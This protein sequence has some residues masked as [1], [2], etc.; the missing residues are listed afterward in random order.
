MTKCAGCGIVLQYDDPLKEGY[1]KDK[2]NPLCERCFRIKNYNEYKVTTRNNNDYLNILSNIKNNDITVVVLSLLEFGD[3]SL[4]N[5]TFGNN[6]ILCLTKRDLLP[7]SLIDEKIKKYFL[8]RVEC[9]D[10]V[11]VSSI[12]NY[13]IDEL[14]NVLKENNTKNGSFYFVGYTNAGK[15]TLINKLLKNYTHLEESL[16]SSA[17]PS[18]TLDTVSLMIDDLNIIDTPGIINDGSILNY[19]DY[20]KLKKYLPNKEMRPKIFQV[21][22]SGALVLDDLLVLRYDTLD[23]GSIIAF[24][25]NSANILH[26]KNKDKHV[27]NS[28]ITK[29]AVKNKELVIE[30]L[31]FFK[32]VGN[33][34]LEIEINK[35]TLV[36]TRD[37]LID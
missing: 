31:C 34:T 37:S 10:I 8:D 6:I 4:I 25:N 12:K 5:K 28:K 13:Q 23:K 3:L 21:K 2:N 1:A 19:L 27:E 24:I 35:D 7:K 9:L 33:M 16:T 17:Y 32:I 15:S 22:K 14:L 30:G 29:L 36:Y 26:I 18:T 20:S 11:L